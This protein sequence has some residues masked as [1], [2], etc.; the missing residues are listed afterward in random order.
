MNFEKIR[1]AFL[2][3][4]G[5]AL[6]T[7]E[8]NRLYFTRFPA[9]DGYLL[10]TGDEVIL[11][12]DSRYIEAAQRHARGCDRILLYKGMEDSIKPLLEQK[13]IKTLEAESD[14]LTVSELRCLKEKTGTEVISDG[15]LD[16]AVDSLRAVKDAGEIALIK[17]AQKIAEDAF[18]H[19]LGFI[20]T[21]K[22]EKEIALELDYYMLSH[23]A[24]G[25]SFETIAV[26]GAN[27]SLPHGVPSDKKIEKG[28]FITMDFGAVVGGYHSDMTRT[29]AVGFVSGEQKK[30]YDT[31][32]A[33]QQ[34]GF[35]RLMPGVTGREADA[36]ARSVIADAGYGQCFGHSLGHGVGVEIHEKPNLSPKSEAVLEKGNVVTNEPGIYIPGAFGV[37][38]E[39]MALITG[40]G[41]ENLTSCEKKLIIL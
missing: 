41:Y 30:V 3:K 34:A 25:I 11:F 15:G 14:R 4:A 7:S 40:D 39:D 12:A 37:R 8:V 31:V 6:I 21:D 9:T 36:A 35:T 16:K 5:A 23:G 10:I 20:S 29:V 2:P 38:I 1:N 33:A 27:S 22:T 18:E 24:E 28:D 17:Q 26:S 19:I 13:G 32:L